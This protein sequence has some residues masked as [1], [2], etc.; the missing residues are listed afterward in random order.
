M[1]KR[2]Q[3]EN[4]WYDVVFYNVRVND[5]IRQE[6]QLTKRAAKAQVKHNVSIAPESMKTHWGVV[7]VTVTTEWV[8]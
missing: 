7:K 1:K 4:V 3:S 5:W 2:L 6:W 8:S